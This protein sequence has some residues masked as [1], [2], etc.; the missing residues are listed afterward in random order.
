MNID[1]SPD[2]VLTYYYN[3]KDKN[4]ELETHKQLLK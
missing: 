2:G 1:V 3:V 4:S